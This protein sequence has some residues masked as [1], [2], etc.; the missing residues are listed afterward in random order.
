MASVNITILPT[1]GRN[2]SARIDLTGMLKHI[3]IAIAPTVP[4]MVAIMVISA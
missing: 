1:I 2:V 3:A 4:M